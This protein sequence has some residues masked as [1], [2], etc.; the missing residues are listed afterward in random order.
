MILAAIFFLPRSSAGSAEETLDKLNQLPLKERQTL[1]ERESR[2][3]G[4]VVFYTTFNVA[5]LQDIKKLFEAKYPFL[6]V[7]PFRLGHGRLA[8]KI[9]TEALAGK[10]EA[11]AISIPGNYVGDFRKLGVIAR[12]RTPLRAQLSDGFV[13]K[14]GWI[15]GMYS[16]AY[17]LQY[18]TKL[19]K[20]DEL[21]RDWHDLLEPKWKGQIALDQ[22]GYEWFAGILE[23]MG[24]E[25]GT[26]FARQLVSQEVAIRRGHTLLSQLVAAGE[27][28]MVLDQYDH[29]AYRAA[30]SGSPTNYLFLNP[31]V[32]EGPNAI[33]ITRSSARPHGGALLMDFV[34]SKEI[35]HF[36]SQRGRRMGHKEVSYLPNPPAGHRWIVLNPEK[37]GPRY[38]DLTKRYRDIFLAR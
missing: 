32:A 11:D 36:L 9:T 13:D 8:N 31:I 25:K 18:N 19:V 22:E 34:L 20:P 38:G 1:L 4:R 5:D 29:I 21:P 10:L 14:E 3:E 37:W 28:K 30:Q 16:T 24:E 33:W 15:H 26:R 17:V 12:N 23:L 6:K 2:K 35:Q 7:E 27:F